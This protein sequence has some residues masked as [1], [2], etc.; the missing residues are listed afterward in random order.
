MAEPRIAAREGQ[1]LAAAV[2]AAVCERL[3]AAEAHFNA[4]DRAI[5]DGDHGHNLS[6]AARR[7]AEIHGELAALELPAMIQRAG[8][9]IVMSVG[10]ASGPLYGTLLLE[11]GKALPLH[12]SL[13][14]WAD[15]FAVGVEALARRGRAEE[16][17]KTMLDVLG[18][19]AG[20]LSANARAGADRALSALR[21]AA[22]AGFERS[23]PLKAKRGRA[24]FVGERAVGADD[25]GAASALLC[26]S[27]IVEFLGEIPS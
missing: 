26:I 17:D 3:L 20:A 13:P 1:E 4:L 7:L 6:R 23:R 2:F 9:E 19:A 15:A 18:P 10:G 21:D 8:K 24:A 16:G 12:P 22:A 25:P 11:L 27:T 14:E 5:G